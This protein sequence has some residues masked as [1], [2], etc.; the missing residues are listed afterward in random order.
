MSRSKTVKKIAQVTRQYKRALDEGR[1]ADARR[2][3]K[4]IRKLMTEKKLGD[5]K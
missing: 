2:L 3:D 4:R 1:D 5:L